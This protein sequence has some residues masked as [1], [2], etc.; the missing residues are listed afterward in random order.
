MKS[1]NYNFQ[2]GA[3]EGEDEDSDSFNLDFVFKTED[4]MA[5]TTL[6]DDAGVK[7][8]KDLGFSTFLELK[9]GAI[10][11]R[12]ET[13]WFLKSVSLEENRIAVK[14][15]HTRGDYIISSDCPEVIRPALYTILNN[16]KTLLDC[17]MNW[18]KTKISSYQFRI[19][20][21]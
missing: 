18:A 9:L 13:H 2:L 16:R 11:K 21:S 1:Q 15:W 12:Q 8:I 5:A 20:W 4:V 17:E 10:C 7:Q 19:Y 6:L 14:I 3:R